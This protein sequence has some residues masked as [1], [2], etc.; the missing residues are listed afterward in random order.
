MTGGIEDDAIG[1]SLGKGRG[2]LVCLAL[3]RVVWRE[4]KESLGKAFEGGITDWVGG[5]ISMV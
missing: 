1:L 2:V 5:I 4:K 3:F